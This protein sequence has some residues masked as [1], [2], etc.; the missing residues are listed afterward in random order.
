[1]NEVDRWISRARSAL[2]ARPAPKVAPTG[3]RVAAPIA[4]ARKPV[5]HFRQVLGVALSA[6]RRAQ[7]GHQ[8]LLR[9]E[10]ADRTHDQKESPRI[11]FVTS[12]HGSASV[13]SAWR[14]LRSRAG[15]AFR[16]LC[17]TRSATNSPMRW[18]IWAN[19]RSR[20]LLGLSA[21]IASTSLLGR[22]HLQP[23]SRQM[24]AVWLPRRQCPLST[25]AAMIAG[26]TRDTAAA[27]AQLESDG[28]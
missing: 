22:H 13:S 28:L 3:P 27:R 6:G 5:N 18:R 20:T 16:A 24:W 1:M 9:R 17:R 8:W 4:K 2:G 25:T 14:L 19:S 23:G 10:R 7:R 21:C 26:I 11:R 12:G 15:F